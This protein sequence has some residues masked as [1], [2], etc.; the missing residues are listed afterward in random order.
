MTFHR[1]QLSDEAL[2]ELL[3]TGETTSPATSPDDAPDHVQD[4]ELLE[5]HAAL[6]SYRTETLQWAE[7]RSATQPSLIPAARRGR[8]WAA[9]PQ[10]SLATVAAVTIA[11][12]VFHFTGKDDPPESTA[13]T[14]AQVTT[15]A[16]NT[17]SAADI[18]ED[19][20]LL[21][22]IDAALSHHRESPVAA[23]GLKSDSDRAARQ[24]ASG[25]SE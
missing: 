12:G 1:K 17:A 11:A 3:V 9:V 23:L 24:D 22:S 10:W 8:V 20:R 6:A 18:A 7:R 4:A 16:A 25:E 14:S 19:N 15:T 21:S 13:S 2:A 5:M